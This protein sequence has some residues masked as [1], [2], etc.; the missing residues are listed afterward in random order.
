[1]A[2]TAAESLRRVNADLRARLARL[3]PEQN[4]PWLV[5][6]EDLSE[7]QAVISRAA[8]LRRDIAPDSPPDEELRKEISDYR[9]NVE[10]LAKILPSVQGRLLAEKARLQDAQSHVAAIGAWVRANS[11]TL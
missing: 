3:Q 7:L 2:S 8:N 11:E 1:M 5:K 4:E 6:A 9:S 10:E